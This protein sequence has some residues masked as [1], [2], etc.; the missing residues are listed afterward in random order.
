MDY[1]TRRPIPGPA[2]PKGVAG[3][4]EFDDAGRRLAIT[5]TT[6]T[7]AG[8]VWSWDLQNRRLERW[9]YSELGG[10]DPA[11]MVEPDLV[12]FRSFDGKQIPAFVYKPKQVRGRAPVIIDIHGGPEGQSRP[13]FSTGR[14]YWLNELGAAVVVPNVRGSSGYG[15]TWIKLD[16]AEKREDS[17]KDIGALLDWIATQPDL[18]PN[19]VVV[20]GGSY[21]GYMV[22]ASLT[23][24]ND[25]LAGGVD[26]VGISNFI[27]FLNNTEGYRRDLRRVEYGDERDPAMRAVFER[28]SPLNNMQKV[29]KPLLVIQGANDPRVPKTEADQVVAKVRA[30][31]G[32]AWYLL[33]KD[34]GH[35]FAK[36]QNR[37]V[38]REV[39]TLFFRRVFGL[40]GGATPPA[41]AQR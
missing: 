35:G 22:L 27:T 34:E 17:V 41:A 40:P 15:K 38:Q 3:G 2:L 39:E 36:K 19:R 26:I 12:R 32:D 14:Q 37:D 8:D 11:Q 33:A 25:R 24:F 5:M 13:T 28:I 30:N 10:L 4:L 29:T 1:R 20:Y 16:N 6:P 7:S 31:G 21:G 23:H 18:D 9:T